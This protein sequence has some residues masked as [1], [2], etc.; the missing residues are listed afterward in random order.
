MPDKILLA[1][2]TVRLTL[3]MEALISRPGLRVICA[4]CGEKIMNEREVSVQGELLC[5]AC[6]GQGGYY[7]RLEI[8]V[9]DRKVNIP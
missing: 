6:A 3:D 1:V 5:K 8:R 7:E 2:Q 9:R 4:R